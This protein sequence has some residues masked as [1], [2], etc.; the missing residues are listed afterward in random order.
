MRPC[1][2]TGRPLDWGTWMS[3]LSRLRRGAALA[4]LVASLGGCQALL[5]PNG[6]QN[7][8]EGVVNADAS[9]RAMAALTR[10][11][12][13]AAE[14]HALTA[15]RYNSRDG[16]GLLAA[17]LAYQ[18]LGRHDLARQYYEVIITGNI[19]GSIMTPGDGGVVMPRS[20]IDVA[21]A[22]MAAIDKMTGRYVPRSA[23][24]SGRAP[25][26]SAVGAPPLPFG[27]SDPLAASTRPQA[28][29][30]PM[31]PIGGGGDA[32]VSAAEANATG[33]F[34]ILKRLLDEGLVTPDEYRVRRAANT[35]A[36]LPYTGKTPAAGLDR[37]IPPDEA[38]SAR[39]RALAQNLEGRA[40]T[41]AEHAAERNTILDALLPE[42]PR[43]VEVPPL[44]PKDLLEAGQSIGRVE[45]LL[46]A[47][48][49]S[50]DEAAKEKA[51]IDQRYNS[52]MSSQVVEGSVTGLRP[53]VTS[54]PVAAQNGGKAATPAAK[55]SGKWGVALARAGTEDEARTL[56]DGIKRKFPEELGKY[57]ATFRPNA[58]ASAWRVLVGPL[59][60]KT[61]ASKLC[62]T[63]KLHRQSCDPA[64]M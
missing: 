25:G 39:L 8:V 22:N 23:A 33:R 4:A 9:D 58:E 38:L 57:D 45:R 43:K 28:A 14:R 20:I 6:T 62:K 56:W 10:G 31:R 16:L 37:P 18:G 3:T 49:I 26:A 24:E 51:A 1:S 11:D 15:L 32:V 17:G 29:V 53:A 19:P 44:P 36:L 55:S 64:S 60:S 46:A 50:A 54:A 21:R 5:D 13:A 30:G 40:I 63:L 41:A 27:A 47:G 42:K 48:L 12:Y 35:G 2:G 34:R 61:A 59:A 52:Q 7:T